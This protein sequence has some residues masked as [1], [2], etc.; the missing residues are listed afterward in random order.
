M[1]LLLALLLLQGGT[2][3]KGWVTGLCV[4]GGR[5]YS[6]SQAGVFAGRGKDAKLVHRPKNRAIGIAVHRQMLAIAGGRPAKSGELIVIGAET[7]TMQL[8]KDLLYAVA[9]APDGKSVA[10]AAADGRVLVLDCPSLANAREV[11]RHTAPAR[12]VAF[13][14]DGQ[15]LASG[16]LDRLVQIQRTDKKEKPAILE[17]H[18]GEV[19]C[20]AFSADGRMLVS[21]ARD[22]KVRLHTAAGRYVRTWK[23]LGAE[24]RGVTW[25]DATIF[26]ALSNGAV[27]A[28][29][30]VKGGRRLVRKP[31]GEPFFSIAV[32]GNGSLLGGGRRVVEITK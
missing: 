23:D 4:A 10:C 1:R 30:S 2:P 3:H 25:R 28:F 5:T 26:A 15:R 20:L 11:F 7:R 8:A 6:C 17:E 24:V 18:T 29:D 22:G 9:V 32:A 31:D 27:W 19:E 16:G 14:P 21:G 12:V 13:S